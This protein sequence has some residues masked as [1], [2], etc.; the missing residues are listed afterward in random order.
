MTTTLHNATIGAHFHRLACAIV[1][2]VAFTYVAGQGLGDWIHWLNDRLAGRG[3]AHWAASARRRPVALLQ[4][5]TD[6]PC[7]IQFVGRA[8]R[9]PLAR[10]P[11][12]GLRQIARSAGI[13]ETGGR[14]VR[15]ARKA[16][17]IFAIRSRLEIID[18]S[19]P[20]ST[21]YIVP[22]K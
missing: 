10:I 21:A 4:P 20:N 2:L 14:N 12:V 5:A 19:L 3:R 9:T 18:P 22:R 8:S 13:R 16:D 15:S 1:P 6:L 11:V 17:L 7:Y